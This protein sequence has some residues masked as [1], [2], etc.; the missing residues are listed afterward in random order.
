MSIS[1]PLKNINFGNLLKPV[2][3][4][5]MRNMLKREICSYKIKY[6]LEICFGFS[7]VH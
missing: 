7:K 3:Q 4:F 1:Y 2:D 5:R 6:S